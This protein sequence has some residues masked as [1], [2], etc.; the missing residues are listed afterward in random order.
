MTPGALSLAPVVVALALAFW[1]RNAAFSLLV[2]CVAG[3]I[4]AGPDPL[5]GLVTT[6]QQALGN[7][8]FVWVMMI[9]VAVGV[10]IAFYLRAGVI[11]AFADWASSR[12][13]TRRS[14]KGF[15]WGLGLFIFF[16]DYFSPLFSGP[17][18][19]PLTDRQRVSREM[20]AYL[21]DSGSAPVAVLLPL[22][23]WA[24][25]VA[26]LLRGYGPIDT[27]DA[28]MAVFVQAIPYNFYGWIAVAL[29]G[30]VAFELVPDIGPMR[31]AELRARVEG[32][33]VRDGAT[34]LTG[35]ELDQIHPREGAHPHLLPYLVAPVTIVLGT[36][37]GTFV[38]LGSAKILEAFLLAVFYQAV[39]M[40]VGRH[41]AGVG[42]AMD[43]AVK[44]LKGVMPAII[45][46]ALAYC[47]NHVSKSLGA[48]QYVVSL[49]EGWMTAGL[50]PV[51]TFA[52]AG[53]ISFFTGTSW[54]TYAILTPFV[55]PVAL[56]LSQGVIDASV[57][58]TVGALVGGGLWGD[59][60]SPVS[61]TSCLSSFGAGSDHM[62]HVTTQLPY[63]LIGGALAAALFA[64]LGLT[65]A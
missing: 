12:I 16:S 2:G 65:W 17:I 4:I 25:Y 50:I 5:S 29:A 30:I 48:Q 35:E 8:D 53:A 27:V 55:M 18:A 46:L 31:A 14:A 52:T 63:A 47:I 62:D 38:V 20:L 40:A 11:A 24:V 51:I 60:C 10:M 45:I 22:S 19:R 49:T 61:D 56:S 21:L 42:D 33:L 43:V 37:I 57:L 59:H 3:A 23:A 64:M 26:G 7:A 39:A 28:G 1:T 36:A 54:G 13:H 44:G 9:E 15:A 32:K 41:F 34:P 58:A 6:F